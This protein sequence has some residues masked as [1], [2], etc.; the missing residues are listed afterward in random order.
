M[1]SIKKPL[2]PTITGMIRMD[3][4]VAMETFHPK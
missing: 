4:T 1:N 2:C 3:H